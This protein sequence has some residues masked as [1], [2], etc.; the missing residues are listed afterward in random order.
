MHFDI[1]CPNYARPQESTS[2]ELGNFTKIAPF[3]YGTTS[4]VSVYIYNLGWRHITPY[5]P[6][7]YAV[8]TNMMEH[9]FLK[10]YLD[11]L[12]RQRVSAQVK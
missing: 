7:P 6:V 10:Q 5:Y 11:M 2:G 9:G 12:F 3:K 8:T 4:L 1:I